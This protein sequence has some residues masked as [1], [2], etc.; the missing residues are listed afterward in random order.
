[1]LLD[2]EKGAI[3]SFEHVWPNTVVKCCFFHLTQNIWRH[4]QS[5]GLQSAYTHDEELAMC[6]RRIPA[7]A[8]A[9]PADVHDL[10]DQVAMDLPL[11]SEIGE[12]VDYFERTYIGRTLASGYHV[13]ATFPID[14]HRPVGLPPQHALRAPPYNQRRGGMAPQLQCHCRLPSPHHMEVPPSPQ[15]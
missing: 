8:F 7:L 1:M 14:L 3:T 6:I 10:F 11:T 5:V 9:R 15:A 4:V 12:L 13:A 2:F